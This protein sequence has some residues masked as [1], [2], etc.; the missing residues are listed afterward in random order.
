MPNEFFDNNEPVKKVFT[1]NKSKAPAKTNNTQDYNKPKL[2]P[3]EK[4]KYR[5]SANTEDDEDLDLDLFGGDDEPEEDW[6]SYLSNED[7]DEDDL[8]ED[9]EDLA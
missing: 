9:D 1:L 4:D 7:I 8:E 5:I 6:Q 2:K 3:A